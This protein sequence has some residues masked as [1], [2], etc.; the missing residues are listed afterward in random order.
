MDRLDK[1]KKKNIESL[2]CFL[3]E[4]NVHMAIN[5]KQSYI[6]VGHSIHSK[7]THSPIPFAWSQGYISDPVVV[8]VCCLPS[9]RTTV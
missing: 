8:C 5:A 4:T 2:I 7:F 3:G 6:Y 1:E 9:H